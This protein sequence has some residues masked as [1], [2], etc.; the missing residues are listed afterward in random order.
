L[1]D[2]ITADAERVKRFV[3]VSGSSDNGGVISCFESAA[4]IGVDA[5]AFCPR[6]AIMERKDGE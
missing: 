4:V 6:V 5:L 3:G 1:E 2:N